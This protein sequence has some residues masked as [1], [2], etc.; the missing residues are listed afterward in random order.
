MEKNKSNKFVE[1]IRKE[2]IQEP[3]KYVEYNG[4]KYVVD[5]QHRLQA[6]KRLKIE[7]V[8]VEKVELPYAGYK[9]IED[10]LWSD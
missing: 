10:L 3:I 7:D 8:P 5:G 9:T 6:A 2:E 1:T 4:K